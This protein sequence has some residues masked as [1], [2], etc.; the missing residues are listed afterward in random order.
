MYELE[1]NAMIWG[2]LS[3]I[4]LNE[5]HQFQRIPVARMHWANVKTFKTMYF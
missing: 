1:L 2:T 4:L 5:K 3:N